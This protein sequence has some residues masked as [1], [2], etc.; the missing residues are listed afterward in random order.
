MTA[1]TEHDAPAADRVW[2]VPNLLSMLR[3]LGV[4]LFLWLALGPHADGWALLVLVIAGITDYL[5]GK[6]A[7]RW[8]QTSRLGT[9]LDPSV[10]RL[11]I[12]A[13][14]VALTVRGIVPVWLA[15]ILPLRDFLLAFTLPVLRRHGYGPL[16]VHF[17]GKAATSALL[18][19]FPLLLVSSGSGVVATI[20]RPL[21]WG[22]T[23]WGVALYWWAGWLY[24]VHM[25]RLLVADQG[26]QG[27]SAT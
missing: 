9:L 7:R 23:G 19:A 6:I 13:T 15:V 5:D 21:G 12:L 24:L 8:H 17:V 22:F 10:D 3:L 1:S 25:R 4:P 26:P 14:I 2:T 16:P 27:G 20:A 11:Y 18:Y